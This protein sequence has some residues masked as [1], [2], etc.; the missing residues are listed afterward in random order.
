MLGMHRCAHASRFAL[1]ATEAQEAIISKQRS[2][3]FKQQLI[4]LYE[5]SITRSE[6]HKATKT[7]E[8]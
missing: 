4:H 7:V 6:L 5:H 2:S 8:E 3:L 1:P